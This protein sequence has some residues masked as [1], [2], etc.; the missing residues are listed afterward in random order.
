MRWNHI[1]RYYLNLRPKDATPI[2]K[3]EE[4]PI[5]RVESNMHDYQIYRK[6]YLKSTCNDYH[7]YENLYLVATHG[8]LAGNCREANIVI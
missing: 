7:I 3:H 6:I 4:K 5:T 1:P 8:A 2:I